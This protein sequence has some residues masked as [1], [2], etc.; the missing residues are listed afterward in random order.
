M[1]ANGVGVIDAGYRGNLM[2]AL[3]YVPTDGDIVALLSAERERLRIGRTFDASEVPTYKV[4]AGRRLAQI[5]TQDQAP[6]RVVLRDLLTETPS[7]AAA[8]LD[9]VFI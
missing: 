1:L 9:Q 5:C 7:R 8:R 2:L 6:I 3:K 4:E